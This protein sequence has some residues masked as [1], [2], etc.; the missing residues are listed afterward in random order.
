M[1]KR[2][3]YTSITPL[4]ANIPRQ[5]VLDMLHNHGE[6]IE[7]NPLV[8]GHKPVEAPKN[9][10]ADEFFAVWHE[11]T[12]R[13]QWVPG[14]GKAGS[15]K[16]S[17]K[18]VFHDMPWGL[19]THVYAPAGVDLRQKF[20]VR[21]NQ[22]GEPREARE[23]GE[24]QAPHDGLYLK[25]EIQITCNITMV[26]YVKK[27]MKEATK[28][29]VERLMKKATLLDAGQLQAMFENGKLKTVNPAVRNSFAANAQIPGSPQL[30]SQYAQPPVSP[31]MMGMNSPRMLS[32][33]QNQYYDQKNGNLSPGL[34]GLGLQDDTKRQSGLPPYLEQ[35]YYGNEQ[36]N[37]VPQ[38]AYARQSSYGNVPQPRQYTAELAG[39]MYYNP[40]P[41]P[42]MQRPHRDSTVTELS[43]SS[44]TQRTSPYVGGSDRSDTASELPAQ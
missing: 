41:S 28:V 8:I 12:E 36:T 6:I 21:G 7:L 1:G 31:Q 5:L 43:G 2:T 22:P 18:G 44:P 37:N 4:P 24:M 15:G 11:I 16:I 42:N 10:E 9:A 27:G 26:G 38:G 25:E 3:L 13:I 17:F 29:M 20:Q 34:H 33:E 23:L 39:S 35:R 14:L 30:A 32:A 40:Q 19:Q